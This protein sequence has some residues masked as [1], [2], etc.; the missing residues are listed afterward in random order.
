[1]AGRI[2][3][4]FIDDLL[5]RTDI[6]GV[7]GERVPLR[8]AGSNYKALCPFHEERTPSFTVSPERQTYRC[9]GCGAHGTVIG[10]LMD[11]DRLGFREA[12]AE[13]AAR[14]GLQ[15]PSVSDP[16]SSPREDN[17][18][19]YAVLAKADR[20][21]REALRSH[22]KRNA[23]VDYLRQRG[24]SGEVAAQFGI[25]FAPPGWN[26]L[27]KHLD[28]PQ[29][30]IKAG[31]IIERDGKTYD[32]FRDR[33][34]FPIHDRRGR[35]VAFGARVV[36]D[37]EP[38]YLNSP[39]S[40]IFQ[41]GREIYGLYHA[42]QAQRRIERLI[43]VEGYMDVIALTQAGIPGAV[44]TLGTATTREQALLLLRSAP[45][46]VLCFDGDSAGQGAAFRAAEN[47]LPVLQGDRQ[48]RV[49][50]LPQGSDPDD[51]IRQD[52]R[53]AFENRLNNASPVI[54]L[55]LS[56]LHSDC[57]LATVDGRTRMLER[58]SG[59]L[60]RIPDGILRE[61]LLGRLADLTHT[62]PQRIDNLC[63]SQPPK[64]SHA[65]PSDRVKNQ[66]VSHH[67]RQSSSPLGG[68][69]DPG[70]RTPVRHAIALL[71]QQPQLAYLAGDPDRFAD[72]GIAGLELLQHLL[73]IIRA[74]P[75]TTTARLLEKFR[76][77]RH[78]G[79]LQ[80][81]AAWQPAERA[82]EREQE[83]RDALMRIEERIIAREQEKI[84][85]QLACQPQNCVLEQRLKDAQ[86]LQF[87]FDKLKA[88]GLEA[89]TEGAEMSR[90]RNHFNLD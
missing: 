19:L 25:G 69:S 45:E 68:S 11:H 1:M 84:I 64:S 57:D 70:R 10:F 14:V 51:L 39:E 53:E 28:A 32:R 81:L 63:R 79:A 2:P 60:K 59:L 9:F 20:F 17:E 75:H 38:K 50:I 36:T 71:L 8:Q 82:V 34:T 42:L 49:M 7:I 43:V 65:T 62:D 74:D 54:E 76:D 55:Y 15:I 35:V 22:P 83:M 85:E 47:L 73:E 33:I 13:L 12:V 80:K 58:A 66:Q 56:H 30:A 21:Y 44:A 31:L 37:G 72:R 24:I 4:E 46:V 52:G 87:L 41:K 18:P 5:Q 61:T 6:V 40:P 77:D 86:R 67:K 89:D 48:V 23:A 3:Q 29:D 88:Q 16:K 90:L 78:E 26:N 27:L